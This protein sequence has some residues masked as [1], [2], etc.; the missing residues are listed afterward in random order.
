M[1]FS[2]NRRLRSSKS[3]RALFSETNIH[4]KNLVFP[5]FICKNE[6]EEQ[7]IFGS[8][9]LKRL[10]IKNAIKEIKECKNL[11][12][13][14]FLLFPCVDAKE[15]DELGSIAIEKDNLICRSIKDIK[16][17]ITDINILSDIALDPYTSHGHD[18]ALSKC[19]KFIDNDVTLEILQKQAVNQ[20]EAGSDFIAPSDMM[21]GRVARIRKALDQDNL[22]NTGI[23]SY[24]AKFASNLYSPFRDAI[25]SGIKTGPK[26][27]KTYQMDIRNLKLSIKSIIDDEIQNCD[28]IIVKPAG[29]YLDIINQASK[30]TNLPIFGYQVSGEYVMV[31][32]YIKFANLER[33]NI[34]TESLIAIKRSGATGIISYFAKEFALLYNV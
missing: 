22:I 18:G 13:N 8:E 21:D 17:E 20:A 11:G 26:D 15:K 4:T 6:S 9:N 2:R 32:E 10:S 34:I 28:A 7:R 3:I 16:N 5:I 31:N 29:W 24:S 25:D 33:K 30:I 1:N 27:K 14:S 19:G 12:I 23:I